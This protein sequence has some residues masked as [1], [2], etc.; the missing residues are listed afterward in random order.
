[1]QESFLLAVDR[2]VFKKLDNSLSINLGIS[3]EK[4]HE[5]MLVCRT[6]VE[7][8]EVSNGNSEYIANAMHE[9]KLLDFDLDLCYD[10]MVKA[11]KVHLPAIGDSW[12]DEAP[13][14]EAVEFCT[15]H[16]PGQAVRELY[17]SFVRKMTAI[18]GD[19]RWTL[20]RSIMASLSESR[21]VGATSGAT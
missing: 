10:V 2:N 5:C 3:V 1:M 19:S 21:T 17:L 8:F 4:L 20:T 16:I 9:E 12:I 18:K 11:L 14:Y 6:F 13:G 7:A 15:H